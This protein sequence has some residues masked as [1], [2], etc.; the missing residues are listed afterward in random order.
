M[1]AIGCLLDLGAV[2]FS[3]WLVWGLQMPQKKKLS[4]AAIFSTRLL[5]VIA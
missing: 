5:C 3:A 1:E 2:I 4:V